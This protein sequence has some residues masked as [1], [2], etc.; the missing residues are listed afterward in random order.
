[1]HSAVDGQRMSKSKGNVVTP[2]EVVAAYGTDALRVYILFLG[3]FEAD[4]IWDDRGIIGVSRFLDRFWRLAT[5]DVEEM[6]QEGVGEITFEQRRQQIIKRVTEDMARYRF[7]TAVA[8]LMAYLNTLYEWMEVMTSKQWRSAVE[9]LTLL[10]C[11]VAP[12]I[13]EEIWQKVLGQT[14][15]VHRQ[16]WP[17]YSEELA[18]EGTVTIVVQVNGRVRDRVQATSGAAED[19]LREL[20]LKSRKVQRYLNGEEIRRIVVVPDRLVN[21]V[22]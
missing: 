5:W 19:S 10:L 11:P 8:A 9:T 18:A 7:N 12:F 13:T 21:I 15:S 14:G 22:V 1:M 17:S 3:P 2:D 20:A 6:A 16:V 4:A